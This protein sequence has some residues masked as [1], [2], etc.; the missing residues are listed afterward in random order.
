MHASASGYVQGNSEQNPR[1]TRRQKHYLQKERIFCI[2]ALE[3]ILQ[4]GHQQ[5]CYLSILFE[6][7]QSRY[8][9][10]INCA[11]A[12][13]RP[14]YSTLEVSTYTSTANLIH[15]SH[16]FSPSSH[17]SSNMPLGAVNNHPCAMGRTRGKEVPHI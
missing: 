7:D 5:L 6:T 10:T 1:N 4:S 11:A 9:K 13:H 15:G 3:E 2:V 14:S 8:A 12:S 16:S 17:I